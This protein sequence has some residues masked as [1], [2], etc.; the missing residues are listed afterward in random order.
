[1]A[2][3]DQKSNREKRKPKSGIAKPAAAP[4]SPF[5][6]A[7]VKPGSGSTKKGR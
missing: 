7:K 1:M 5:P 2:K 4:A 6:T 3:G